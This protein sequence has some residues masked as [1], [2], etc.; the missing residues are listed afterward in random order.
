[1]RVDLL[2]VGEVE[3]E[4]EHRHFSSMKRIG[5]LLQLLLLA[6]TTTGD[7]HQAFGPTTEYGTIV[8][9]AQRGGIDNH[10]V[11]LGECLLHHKLHGF[12]TQQ[13][14]SIGRALTRRQNVQALLPI[15]LHHILRGHLAGKHVRQSGSAFESKMMGHGWVT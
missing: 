12:G 8:G 11:I 10:I 2:R 9:Y 7:E 5:D 6:H 4:A 1:M 15:V 13:H 14:T 3:D